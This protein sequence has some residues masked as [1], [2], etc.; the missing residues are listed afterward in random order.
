MYART[1]RIMKNDKWMLLQYL[2]ELYYMQLP[3][4][5]AENPRGGFVSTNQNDSNWTRVG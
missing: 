4:K 5:F 2:L 1:K 3:V